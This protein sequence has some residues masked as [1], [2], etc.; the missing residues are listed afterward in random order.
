MSGSAPC[1]PGRLSHARLCEAGRLVYGDPN[2]LSLYGIPAPEMADWGITLLG[3]TAIECSVDAYTT[4]V[5]DALARLQA[6]EAR[7][8]DAEPLI[9]DLFCG[10]G[11][12]GYHLGQRLGR[13]VHASELD[14]AVYQTTRTSPPVPE[15]LDDIRRSR[16][17]LPCYIAIKTNDRIAHDSLNR[18]FTDTTHLRTI[19]PNPCCPKARTWTSTS[20]ASAKTDDTDRLVETPAPR[21]ILNRIP[22][23]V[24]SGTL[25][26]GPSV[27]RVPCLPQAQGRRSCPG[28][29]ARPVPAV[30]PSVR[31][32]ARRMPH[33]GARRAWCGRGGSTD[34]PTCSSEG[35]P[36]RLPLPR[37]STTRLP[38][39]PSRT[40]TGWRTPHVPRTRP[41]RKPRS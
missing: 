34:M 15:I 2:G 35:V 5:A 8:D 23:H 41:R 10:S 32:C 22:V 26:R 13:A 18:S 11:N 6:D 7:H 20:T 36:P 16:H 39:T 12:F 17:G 38:A 19:T 14:P 30:R 24:D 1:S 31:L 28:R 27:H 40:P 33:A 21:L 29:G 37:R 3:R 25:H 9:A 4:P